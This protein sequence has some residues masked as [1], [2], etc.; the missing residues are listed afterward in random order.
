MGQ[1]GMEIYTSAHNCRIFAPYPYSIFE[2]VWFLDIF[3]DYENTS[4][5]LSRSPAFL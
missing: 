4:N 2:F 5:Y 3:A 1:M